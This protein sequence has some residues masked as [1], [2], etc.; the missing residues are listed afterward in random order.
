VVLPTTFILG[1]T[2]REAFRAHHDSLGR[3]A[4]CVSAVALSIFAWRVMHPARGVLDDFLSEHRGGWLDR[5]RPVW[6]PVLIAIPI[7]LAIAACAGFLL[8]AQEMVQRVLVSAWV[9]LGSVVVYSILMRSLSVAQR[10]L[11]VEQMRRRLE[12]EREEAERAAQEA[13]QDEAS[14]APPPLQIDDVDMDMD[15]VNRQTQRLLKSAFAVITLVGLYFV[16]AAVLPALN[17]FDN[18]PVWVPSGAV[19][20]TAEDGSTVLP[21]E[22]VTIADIGKAAILIFLTVAISRNIPG[23]LEIMVLQRLPL[24]PGGRYTT[25]TLVRYAILILGIMLTF[26]AIGIGWSKVQWLAAAV[27]VGLGFGL[28]EIFANFVSGLIILTER[29]VR[30]GD[31]VTVGQVSGVVSRI[32]MRATTV[33]DWDRKELII[34]NKEFVTGQIV[35]WTL[36]SAVLRIAL[37]IGIAY[38][39]DT[40][41]AKRLLLEVARDDPRVLDDPSPMAFF[42]GFGDNSLNFQLRIF[43]DD[44]DNFSSIRDGVNFEIDR[45]FR[46][47][48]IEI[49]FPQR[50]LHIRSINAVLP[51]L[52]QAAERPE[53]PDE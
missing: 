32:Q 2:E 27:S 29:P 41:T 46:E 30:V 50:D 21:V 18:I 53:Q 44:V 7:A 16:W 11:A 35:N 43:I 15:A 47:A 33:T 6:F 36:S 49:S 40:E 45:R 4:F 39:S 9:V 26:D 19:V 51:G 37:D 34:P 3:L 48:N 5:L 23:V 24:S 42:I 13:G 22:A 25:R 14:E 20:T 1:M 8:T 52:A 12:A 31:T 28:Q 17:M 10:R 38:G